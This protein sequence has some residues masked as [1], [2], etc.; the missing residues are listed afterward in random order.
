MRQPHRSHFWAASWAAETV[1]Q[2]RLV[3]PGHVNQPSCEP[4][5]WNV[6]PR[7]LGT[8]AMAHLFTIIKP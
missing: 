6:L 2:R 4:R 5:I 7:S 8:L 3:G 1:L